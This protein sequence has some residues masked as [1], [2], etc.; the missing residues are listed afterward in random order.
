MIMRFASM[1][2]AVLPICFSLLL[3]GCADGLTE[4]EQRY[5][6]GVELQEQNRLEASIAAYAEATRCFL[7]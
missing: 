7:G 6:A 4:A 3:I 2:G 5:N 1:L